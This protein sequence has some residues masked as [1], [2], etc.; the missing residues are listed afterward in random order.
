MQDAI[1]II[2]TYNEIENI[3]AIIR[4]V[5]NQEKGFDI[6]VVDDN[7]PDGTGEK[8]K[9]LQGEFPDQ[10]FLLSRAN[11]TGLGTAYIEGFKWSL[12]KHYSYIFE[13]DADFSHN[14]NDLIHLYNACAIDDADLSIGSRYVDGVNVVNWPMSRVLLSY[15]ASKYVRLITRM[16]ICDTTAGFVCYKRQVL[17]TINL[18]GIK[19]VGYAFQIEMKFKA[20]LKKFKIVEVPVIFT[21]RTKGKSKM[22]GGIISEAIFG[23]INMKFKSLFSK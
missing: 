5:F 15:G 8:V 22:S 10:L 6:L 20:Y 3:E 7:S 13:M 9:T 23:V 2:P 16:K 17:E 12:K 11:K 21:D 1:V 18:D 19:F 14:P 4:A